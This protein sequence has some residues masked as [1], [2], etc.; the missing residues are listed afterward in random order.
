V[1]LIDPAR[2]AALELMPQRLWLSDAVKGSRAVS[3]ISRTS[4]S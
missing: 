3:L 4:R 2:P 1:F